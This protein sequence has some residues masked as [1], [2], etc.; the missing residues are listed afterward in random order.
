MQNGIVCREQ[1]RQ[2][3]RQVEGE[4]TDQCAGSHPRDT[5][6]YGEALPSRIRTGPPEDKPVE[7]GHDLEVASSF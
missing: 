6:S 4:D 5:R 1:A 3:S 7:C 2:L